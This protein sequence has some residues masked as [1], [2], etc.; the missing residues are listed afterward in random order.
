ME[1]VRG[2]WRGE[3]SW[4]KDIEF[5]LN[6]ESGEGKNNT[7]LDFIIETYDNEI[8]FA[9]TIFFVRWWSWCAKWYH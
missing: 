8:Y 7:S 4:A 1:V 2:V 3:F 6:E 5:M 9:Y